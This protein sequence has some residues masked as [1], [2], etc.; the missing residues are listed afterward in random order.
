MTDTLSNTLHKQLNSLFNYIP[1]EGEKKYNQIQ[2]ESL[3]SNSI[4]YIQNYL[5]TKDVQSRIL[6]CECLVKIV[7]STSHLEFLLLDAQPPLPKHIYI[8]SLFNLGTLLKN[9]VE[10]MVSLR[11]EQMKLNES[12]PAFKNTRIS[13]NL[14][15]FEQTIFDKS[16]Q[17][18]Q[19]ILTIDFENNNAIHQ[20][21]SIYTY[22][23]FF[24][25]DNLKKCCEYLYQAL[26]YDPSNY[27]IHYNLGFIHQKMNNLHNAII[28]YKTSI[29]VLSTI[30][31]KEELNTEQKQV[32]MNDYNGIANIYRSLKQWPDSLH[33]LLK[34][35]R[36]EPTD[37]DINNQLGVVYTEMRRTDLAENAYKNAIKYYDKTFISTDPKFLLSEIYLNY[38]HCNSYNGDNKNSIDCY[39]KS[40]QNCPKFMLPFQNKLMNLTYLFEDF[41]DKYY[42]TKQHKLVNKLFKKN[43]IH[44]KRTHK[45][46][47]I[48]IGIISGD[49]VSH[50]VSFFINTF[51]SRYDTSKFDVTCYSEAIINIRN[52]NKDLK[53]KTIKNM[54]QEIAANLIVKDEIDI[55]LDLSGH[56]A[57]NRL[58]I[59][60]FKPAP[61]QI[62][63]LGYPFT[64]GLNTLPV[65]QTVQ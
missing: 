39:N 22:L 51:L 62:T 38:G 55:L 8:E 7:T 50:P 27:T 52:F 5:Q 14:T 3:Y 45:N 44:I 35:L 16:L 33:Y 57:L 42:I 56:T 30:K 10:D 63:Y 11:M 65:L 23:T 47:I 21:I 26:F 24:N 25:Q 29:F 59:F 31:N 4:K 53:F 19:T 61:I 32:M 43:N 15:E 54:S 20:I 41:Q 64:T 40:L 48:R 18:L 28:H 2:Y 6:A 12:N 58:D 13:R 37:P 9:I 36:L 49:F 1:Q 46:K 60:A 34:A 17:Y